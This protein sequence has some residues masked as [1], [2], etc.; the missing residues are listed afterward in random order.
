MTTRE[1][2]PSTETRFGIERGES[3]DVRQPPGITLGLL[4]DESDSVEIEGSIKE[5]M[6][7]IQEES[8]YSM[9][10]TSL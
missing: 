10:L 6:S 9:T 8:K 5:K 2:L 3:M 1:I 7:A 4:M